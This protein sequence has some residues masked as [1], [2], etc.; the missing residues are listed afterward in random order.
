M[1]SDMVIERLILDR[2]V[3]PSRVV[4]GRH[5]LGIDGYPRSSELA[6]ARRGSLGQRADLAWPSAPSVTSDLALGS[7]DD[8]A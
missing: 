6:T 3:E 4:V 2:R 7:L 1:T 5:A 8:A